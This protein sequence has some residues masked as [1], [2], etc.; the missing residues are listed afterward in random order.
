MFSKALIVL[1]LA[2]ASFAKIFTVAPVAATKYSG[3]KEA[4]VRWQD[5][6]SA[7]SLKD[8]GPAQISIYVG[9]Q[10]QQTRLQ[11][12]NSSIDVSLESQV[13]FTVD[14]SIGPD[15]SEYF[16]RFES[17]GFKDP[18]APQFPALAFSAKFTLDSMTGVFS[19]PVLQQ[20]AGQSTAPLGGQTPAPTNS[21]P[22][23]TAASTTKATSSSGTSSTPSPSPSQG[24]ALN[25][26]AGWVGIALGAIVGSMMF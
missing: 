8:F 9:N 3:G 21:S 19:A 15:S 20:I 18:D 22:K 16:I 26:R 5:D 17:I 1:T 24:A 11:T 7:P 2:T 23:P 4:V 12:I 14:A 25:N 10:L 6:G 13:T